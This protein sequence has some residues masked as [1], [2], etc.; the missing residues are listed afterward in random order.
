MRLLSKAVRAVRRARD[1]LRS[2]ALI[3]LYHRVADLPVDPQLLCVSPGHFREHLAILR[4]NFHTLS[5]AELASAVI[6]RRIPNRAVV[7]TF[8]DGYADNLE[9]AKPLLTEY[10]IPATVF[11]ASGWVDQNRPFWWDELALVLLETPEL[12]NEL[13]LTVAG[14]KKCWRLGDSAHYGNEQLCSYWRWNVQDRDCPTPRHET[15][16]QLCAMLRVLPAVQ[17]EDALAQVRRWPRSAAAA[18]VPTAMTSQQLMQLVEGGLVDVGGH[19]VT[20]P[21]LSKLGVEEQRQE[22]ESGK[23]VLE[24]V[25]ARPVSSFS[26]PFGTQADYTVQTAQ[27]V[28]ASGFACAC[29]N[30]AGLVGR[31]SNPFE[32]P[33]LLV[34]NWDGRAFQEHLRRWL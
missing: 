12:P 14:E 8:D 21:V 6:Q 15:Y 11:V 20:H 29:S 18:C 17:R 31:A 24:R 32:L 25:L 3:L 4:Q 30:F 33:R 9:N 28:Q 27:L 34:R 16:R 7:V 2:S 5:L 23:A 1:R 26:Y 13:L 19:T 10:R 22:I